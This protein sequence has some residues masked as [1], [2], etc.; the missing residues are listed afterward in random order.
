MQEPGW[1]G[2]LKRYLNPVYLR[3]VAFEH[4]RLIEGNIERPGPELAAAI[5][6]ALQ[7]HDGM[8]RQRAEHLGDPWWRALSYDWN[9]IAEYHDP[10]CLRRLAKACIAHDDPFS[11]ESINVRR[12]LEGF[13]AGGTFEVTEIATGKVVNTF[14]AEGSRHG[15][16]QRN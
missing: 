12:L 7:L 16:A 6:A 5:G 13:E 4:R 2:T 8:R 11:P 3:R 9:G 15:A 1:S 10:E 14:T